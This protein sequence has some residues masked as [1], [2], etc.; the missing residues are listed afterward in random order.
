MLL[1]SLAVRACRPLC[2]IFQIAEDARAARLSSVRDYSH[3]FS[4]VPLLL[5]FFFCFRRLLFPSTP[6]ASRGGL[7]RRRC[8]QTTPDG[9]SQWLG[10]RR[11]RFRRGRQGGVGLRIVGD[12]PFLL[13]FFRALLHAGLLHFPAQVSS[14]KPSQGLRAGLAHLRARA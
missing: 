11:R 13:F 5:F 6:C 8:S 2:K 1:P 10:L 7:H 12:F 14:L 4:S 9:L 3:A